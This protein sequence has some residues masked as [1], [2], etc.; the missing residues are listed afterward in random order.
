M[1][2]SISYNGVRIIYII[3][4]MMTSGISVVQYS[5]SWVTGIIID[6][7]LESVSVLSE[8]GNAIQ[9]KEHEV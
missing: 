7:R 2:I 5:M 1:W 3:R 4:R 9:G 6:I 8:V